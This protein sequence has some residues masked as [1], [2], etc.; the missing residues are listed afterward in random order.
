[1]RRIQTS[2]IPKQRFP[3]FLDAFFAEK[4]ASWLHPGSEVTIQVAGL[5]K[6]WKG[7]ILFIRGGTGRVTY[8]SP[9]EIPPN[10]LKR[11]LVSVRIQVDWKGFFSPEE[12]YGLGRTVEVTCSR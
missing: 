5:D 2:N 4:V 8:D 6:K 7:K 1:M 12:F 9:V 10:A 11:R 3:P